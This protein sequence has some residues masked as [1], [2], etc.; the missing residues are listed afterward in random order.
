MTPKEWRHQIKTLQ[1]QADALASTAQWLGTLKE[2][3]EIIQASLEELHV[4]E[5]DM[6]QQHEAIV[7]AQQAVVVAHQRYQQVFDVDPDEHV[8]TDHC[9]LIQQ[10]NQATA[11]LLATSQERLVGKPLALF[12]PREARRVWRTW[13]A[14]LT[15]EPRRQT[16][17]GRLQPWCQPS[18]AAELSVV[19]LPDP[20]GEPMRL[21]WLLR[22][23]RERLQAEEALRD[24]HNALE[25]RVRERTAALV[26][27]T[28]AVKRLAYRM[29]QDL[30]A[31]L[32]TVQGFLR[33]L[34]AA[35][36]MLHT[37][38]PPLLPTLEVRQRTAVAQTLD[39]DMPEALGCI[40]T[41][42]TGMD[43]RSQAMLDFSR[44]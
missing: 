21:L 17:Q 11:A 13:L 24:A 25:E 29:S 8:I 12:V 40:E 26:V 43:S 3:L 4:A 35:Y 32:V 6:R 2:A 30:R 41:A 10:A 22:D 19:A 23:L 38:L 33:E 27:E 5:E 20:Q 37:L 7:V 15:T 34:R 18:F 14:T 39:H 16:W 28:A 1:R 36:S 42:V 44:R 9:G 31:L